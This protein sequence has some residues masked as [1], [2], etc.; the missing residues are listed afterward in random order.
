MKIA[1]RR[2][3]Y[4][5]STVFFFK[6]FLHDNL[7]GQ[8]KLFEGLTTLF[9]TEG[10]NFFAKILRGE[11]RPSIVC[12]SFFRRGVLALKMKQAPQKTIESSSTQIARFLSTLTQKKFPQ[13]TL[14]IIL[15]PIC[16]KFIRWRL[17]L[18]EIDS[19]VNTHIVEIS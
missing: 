18:R 1:K 14:K 15:N 12:H 6:S 17:I 16:K 4:I 7:K 2:T 3:V 8:V 9:C 13:Q 11:I 10:C 5:C 19:N